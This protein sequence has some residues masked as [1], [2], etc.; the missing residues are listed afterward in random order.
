MK[1]DEGR[2]MRIRNWAGLALALLAMAGATPA[3]AKRMII[4]DQDAAGPGGTDMMS[5]LVLLQAPDVDVLG[6]TVVTGD[7]WRDE[8]VAHALRLL[9]LVGRTGLSGGGG[10]WVPLCAT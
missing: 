4:F 6:V 7:A 5:L 9:E 3:Q 2:V 8:E 1:A 10:A